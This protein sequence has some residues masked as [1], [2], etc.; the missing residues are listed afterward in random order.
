MKKV[1]LFF[2]MLLMASSSIIFSSCEDE[3]DDIES[4]A[5][6]FNKTRF[7]FPLEGGTD[8]LCIIG[9]R[10]LN[11]TSVILVDSE[12]N[13]LSDTMLSNDEKEPEIKGKDDTIYGHVEYDDNGNVKKLDICEFTVTL[14]YDNK[15]HSRNVYRIEARPTD[16]P[17]HE[18]RI[19]ANHR[20]GEVSV[21]YKK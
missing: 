4:S 21:K 20:V 3:Y 17:Y 11:L 13:Y 2:A 8:V 7:E 1:S 19:S 18:L 14:L 12:G 6:E 10:T 5:A 9:M 16:K 15:G